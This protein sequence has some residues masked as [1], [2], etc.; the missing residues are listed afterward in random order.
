MMHIRKRLTEAVNLEATETFN[1]VAEDESNFD[2]SRLPV[3]LQSL[4]LSTKID[5][6][7]LLEYC[8]SIDLNLFLQIVSVCIDD[9]DW[10]VTEIKEAF[11]TFDREDSGIGEKKDISRVLMKL[12]EILSDKNIDDQI[13]GT[14]DLGHDGRITAD[15][16]IILCK[17]SD[18]NDLN[19]PDECQG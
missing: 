9:P 15:D 10:S 18:D 8:T 4:G 5:H 13:I 12:G 2:V 19:T 6:S 17:N 14:S 1:L 3:A 11:T 7:K 16:F